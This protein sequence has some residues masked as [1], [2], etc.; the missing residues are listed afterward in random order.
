MF[1]LTKI[2]KCKCCLKLHDSVETDM[3]LGDHENL[4]WFNCQCG[5]TLVVPEEEV[6]NPAGRYL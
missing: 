5:S 1:T 2:K 4:F 3:H 6:T